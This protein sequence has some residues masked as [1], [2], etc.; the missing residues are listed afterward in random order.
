MG[1]FGLSELSPPDAEE[2]HLFCIRVEDDRPVFK[3]WRADRLLLIV[4]AILGRETL[5]EVWR[6]TGTAVLAL[7]MLR[8][9]GMPERTL[10]MLIW[11]QGWTMAEPTMI[12]FAL[13]FGNSANDFPL[14][15]GLVITRQ[16]STG[17]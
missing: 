6:K 8:R 5:T 11:S 3:P 4:V 10:L 2:F 16:E 17:S 12:S 15:D 7:K 13:C 1:A 9:G 14:H